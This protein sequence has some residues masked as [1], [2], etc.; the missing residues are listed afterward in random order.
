MEDSLE[1]QT[2]G[3]NKPQ[4]FCDTFPNFYSIGFLSHIL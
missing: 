1:F 3:Q 4:L 2:L